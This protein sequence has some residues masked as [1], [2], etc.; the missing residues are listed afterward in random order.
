MRG[1]QN[2][3]L[4]Q[5]V[6]NDCEDLIE[7]GDNRLLFL[8]MGGGLYASRR[9]GYGFRLRPLGPSLAVVQVL[10]WLPLLPCI[11]DHRLPLKL[12]KYCEHYAP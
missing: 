1:T 7:C 9:L 8:R 4:R 2:V 5:S 10:T 11:R 12:R 6:Y 3:T